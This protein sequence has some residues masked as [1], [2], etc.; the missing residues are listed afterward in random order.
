MKLVVNC[1][2]HQRYDVLFAAL[3][4]KIDFSLLHIFNIFN[5]NVIRFKHELNAFYSFIG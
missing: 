1:Y 3:C 2:F 5:C 4:V